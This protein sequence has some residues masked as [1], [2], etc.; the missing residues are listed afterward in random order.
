ML[1][2]SWFLLVLRLTDWSALADVK[3]RTVYND[4]LGT[5]VDV[6]RFGAS[7]QSLNGQTIMLRGHHLPLELADPKAIIL[8]KYPYASC[9]FCGGAG[10]ESVVQVHFR[11]KER[12]F[13]ADEV[14]VVKGRL[15]LNADDFERLVFVL[16]EAERVIW[17][18]DL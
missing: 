15:R 7:L 18:E 5:Y 2:I 1:C 8:S 17:E 3:F 6:P 16:E 4:E 14:I 9:F 10:L 12:R 11:E 13:K